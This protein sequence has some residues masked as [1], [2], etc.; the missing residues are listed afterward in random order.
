M[1]IARLRE[2]NGFPPAFCEQKKSRSNRAGLR[3]LVQN[4]IVVC[5]SNPIGIGWDKEALTKKNRSI[6]Q[7]RFLKLHPTDNKQQLTENKQLTQSSS[8]FFL[9]LYSPH[10]GQP[11]FL[12]AHFVFLF[13]I[14]FFLF[15]S[16]LV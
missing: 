14:I 8:I 2:T 1:R 4:K 16:I 15:L 6:F 3:A 11:I 13:P 7:N 9:S 5:P 12:K 10:A